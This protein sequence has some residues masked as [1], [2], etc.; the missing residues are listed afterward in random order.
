VETKEKVVHKVQK[1]QLVLVAP[2]VS[3]ESLDLKDHLVTLELLELKDS[4][5]RK[6]TVVLV[7]P[8]VILV[9]LA[10]KVLPDNLV[11]LD[12]LE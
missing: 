4:L 2:L 7:E 10:L 9:N 6:E 5:E 8:R 11:H 12:Q 1:D 3:V